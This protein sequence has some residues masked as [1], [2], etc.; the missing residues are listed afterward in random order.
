MPLGSS[1]ETTR[2]AMLQIEDILLNDPDVETVLDR[3][4]LSLTHR[5]GDAKPGG[6]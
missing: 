6:R 3:R 5:P 2:T 4:S 1:L